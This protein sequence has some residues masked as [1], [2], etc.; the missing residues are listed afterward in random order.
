MDL[1]QRIARAP[2]AQEVQ[3]AQ[4]ELAEQMARVMPT[5]PDHQTTNPAYRIN[6][7]YTKDQQGQLILD[8]DAVRAA[9]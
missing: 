3:Q 6:N 4:E 8:K 1:E 9:N 7:A 5:R 2:T